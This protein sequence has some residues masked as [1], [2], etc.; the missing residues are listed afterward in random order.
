MLLISIK[1]LSHIHGI[2]FFQTPL[3]HEIGTSFQDSE[4]ISIESIMLKFFQK[5]D[6]YALNVE[7]T[8]WSIGWIKEVVFGGI[9]RTSIPLTRF[10]KYLEC[11]D[12]LSIKT[13]SG[14]HF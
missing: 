10:D 6:T 3:K 9:K 1:L 12:A 7:I 14:A 4:I 5:S 13:H 11:T 2:I 8:P